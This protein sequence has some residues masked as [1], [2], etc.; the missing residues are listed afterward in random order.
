MADYAPAD[1]LVYVE[2]NNLSEVAQAIQQSDVW[3]AAAPITGSKATSRS[4]LMIAAARAGIGP[5]EAVVFARA[6]VALVV[7][8]LNAT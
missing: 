5:L 3:Q 4:R 1:S 2:F 8:D 7:V 6:Q